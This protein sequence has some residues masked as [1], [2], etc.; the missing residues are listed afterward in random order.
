WSA[1][2]G[3][4]RAAAPCRNHCSWVQAA[5]AGRATARARPARN[6]ATRLC[7]RMVVAP[8]LGRGC[9]PFPSALHHADRRTHAEEKIRRPND[10]KMGER[11][12]MLDREPTAAEVRSL[13]ERA[14]GAWAD[15]HV[16]DD[17]FL[18]YLAE[19]V[20]GTVDL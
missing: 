20:D 14:R 9:P 3:E 7:L 16:A 13:L 15:V 1:A 2:G 19:R 5:A 17:R 12:A 4:R 18:A 11:G 6:A 10:D 8:W